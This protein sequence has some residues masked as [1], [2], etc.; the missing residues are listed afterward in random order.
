MPGEPEV[1]WGDGGGQVWGEE[2]G[3][4]RIEGGVG[5]EG[6]NDVEDDVFLRTRH[7]GVVCASVVLRWW[8]LEIYVGVAGLGDWGGESL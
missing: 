3:E 1:G 7:G 4:G 2:G 5:D 8:R 6:A